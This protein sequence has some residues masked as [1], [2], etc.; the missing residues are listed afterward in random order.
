MADD[1]STRCGEGKV[2]VEFH[3]RKATN[4][5]PPRRYCVSRD[6]LKN[7]TL[8]ERQRREA[9]EKAEEK[10]KAL[11]EALQN[12][13]EA[14]KALDAKNAAD[15]ADAVAKQRAQEKNEA[16]RKN[17]EAQ[18]G[19][20]KLIAQ[21]A[22]S[23]LGVESQ[24]AKQAK[25]D[26]DRLE[27]QAKYAQEQ[28]IQLNE[29]L[30]RTRDAAN[31]KMNQ[32]RK[33]HDA[34]LSDLENR[35]REEQDK[36]KYMTQKEEAVRQAEAV[37]VAQEAYDQ[38]RIAQVEEELH[39]RIQQ[40]KSVQELNDQVSEEL[41][42]LQEQHAEKIENAKSESARQASAATRR[43]L[44]S[45]FTARL[46][47]LEEKLRVTNDALRDAQ[48]EVTKAR[49]AESI[50][51]RQAAEQQENTVREAREAMAR[52]EAEDK[53][54]QIL[55]G[56]FFSDA[57]LEALKCD[58][59]TSIAEALHIGRTAPDEIMNLGEAEKKQLPQKALNLLLQSLAVQGKTNTISKQD[60]AS[61]L[62]V[63]IVDWDKLGANFIKG[64]GVDYSELMRV[65]YVRVDPNIH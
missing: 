1:A 50:A 13:E 56:Q 3:H 22:E 28:I 63:G 49:E 19:H 7:I 24:V 48:I 14:R 30:Q 32:M 42:N 44:E 37:R 15:A 10:G 21:K 39:S 31:A 2:H 43:D 6:E 53:R 23:E 5:D 9:V 51:K 60:L 27:K 12:E 20:A 8:I 26:L 52:R 58:D 33:D 17:L 18:I 55:G 59:L 34:A 16:E 62:G 65:L 4:G 47:V 29:E 45:D 54:S 64:N 25:G 36:L 35:L 57:D 61:L 40:L 41:R 11:L 46:S 38:K